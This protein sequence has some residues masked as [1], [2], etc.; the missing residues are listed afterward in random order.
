MAMIQLQASMGR[1]GR[2]CAVERYHREFASCVIQYCVRETI[3]PTVGLKSR[4]RNG[5]VAVN[6]TLAQLIKLLVIECY[7]YPSIHPS[8]HTY[9]HTYILYVHTYV[10]TYYMYIHTY[11]HTCTPMRGRFQLT[12]KA[13]TGVHSRCTGVHL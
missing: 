11:I 9:I 7:I 12:T 6:V 4:S 8:I 1:W 10:H 5:S 2:I 13:P 3:E